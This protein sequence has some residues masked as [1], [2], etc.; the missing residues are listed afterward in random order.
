MIIPSID[1]Q[2]GRTVQLVQGERLEI[3]AGDP[4]PIAR[5]FGL[6][7]ETAVIDLD[8]AMGIGSNEALVRSLLDVCPCRVGGGIRTAERARMWLDAGARKVI[9]GTAA[10]PEILRQ[11]P[12]ER[13]I[14]ALDAR[15]GEIVVH[16]W[17]S[18]TGLSVIDRM[19]ELRPF[20]SGFLVTF[21]ETEG[22][23]AGLSTDRARPLL[24]AAGDCRI[25][26]AGGIRSAEEIGELDAMGIDAQVGMALYK[27]I[28]HPAEAIAATLRSDRPDGLWP[29][30][31]ADERGVALGLAYSNRQSLKEAIE[32]GRGVYW[33][34]GRGLW[35]KGESSGDVQQLIR[36]DA[37]CDRDTLRFTV[38]QTGPSG[39]FCHLNTRTCWGPDAGLAEVARRVRQPKNAR[40][41]GS[42]T[43]RLL[44]DPALLTSKIL[45]EA[46]EFVEAEDRDHRVREAADLLYFVLVRLAAEG[47]DLS[48][49]D[50]ELAK[51]AL[52]VS[53]RPGDAKPSPTPPTPNATPAPTSDAP[54]GA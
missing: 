50:H 48:E 38:R 25:T 47:I 28:I 40:D 14:A 33:S 41:A 53:R 4:L 22:T 49:I 29:T 32:T 24:D 23:L 17:R 27:G 6:I 45:E 10:S 5:R 34:R 2:G 36:V 42:Y 46:R 44:N 26:V 19:R 54:R 9:L 52:K 1:L 15:D 51:R 8:A 11:L 43:S 12:R 3:D 16:G 13:V 18:R 39:G 37:D 31:V 7:G 30:V 35:R 20:V 21:V